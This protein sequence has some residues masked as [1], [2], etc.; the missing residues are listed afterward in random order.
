MRPSAW[1]ESIPGIAKDFDGVWLF[2]AQDF[3]PGHLADY[4]GDTEEIGV[5]LGDG[6]ASNGLS[7][8]AGA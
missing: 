5:A 6:L 4:A 3:F 7:A 1:T 8:T 2:Q